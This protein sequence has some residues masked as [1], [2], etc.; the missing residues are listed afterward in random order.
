MEHEN[1]R[2][3]LTDLLKYGK[4]S[5]PNLAAAAHDIL[6]NAATLS[7]RAVLLEFLCLQW[8]SL[9][10]EPIFELSEQLSDDDI[11]TFKS[12]Y[13]E[14]IDQTIR[15]LAGQNLSESDFYYRMSEWL[16]LTLWEDQKARA[17]ALYWVL[18]DKLI[19]YF[20]LGEGLSMTNPEFSDATEKIGPTVARARFILNTPGLDQKTKQATLLLEVLEGLEGQDR[21]VLLAN[22]LNMAKSTGSPLSGLLGRPPGSSKPGT[23][24]PSFKF[25]RP[26]ASPPTHHDDADDDDDDDAGDD[27]EIPF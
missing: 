18:I 15:S 22:I 13:A 11:K 26:P 23:T 9:K 24:P 10:N 19:P 1:L 20:H 6:T 21:I 3:S 12:R 8:D 25:P 14:M 17:F 2:E 27:D 4:G 5:K 16:M 7:E